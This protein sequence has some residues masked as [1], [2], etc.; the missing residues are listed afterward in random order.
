MPCV[1]CAFDAF[2]TDFSLLAS[3]LPF[4]GNRWIKTTELNQNARQLPSNTGDHAEKFMTGVHN[5]A[6]VSSVSYEPE[7]VSS[8]FSILDWLGSLL[9]PEGLKSYHSYQETFQSQWRNM[10]LQASYVQ[11]KL[12]DPVTMQSQESLVY[13]IPR[14]LEYNMEGFANI[15]NIFINNHPYLLHYLTLGFILVMCVIL[16]PHIIRFIT[17]IQ[18]L[19]FSSF[20]LLAPYSVDRNININVIRIILDLTV[21][22]GVLVLIGFYIILG[23][24]IVDA[25]PVI[26]FLFLNKGQFINNLCAAQLQPSTLK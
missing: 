18:V 11:A 22:C 6:P 26:K 8:G 2:I 23:N 7:T 4:I 5:P 21:A 9:K 14:K 17:K 15:L 13:S 20:F 1:L 19:P 16:I 10:D 24:G 25:V 3:L 12:E